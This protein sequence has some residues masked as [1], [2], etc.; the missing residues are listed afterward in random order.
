[1][2]YKKFL[3]SILA[4]YLAFRVIS[5]SPGVVLR[6]FRSDGCSMFIDR[7]L[8]DDKDWCECCLSHD[9]AY[10]RGGSKEER[11]AA[12]R[13]FRECI[14]QMTG[15]GHLADLMYEAVRV[16]G[17]PYFPTWYR[18]GYGWKTMRGYK[19]LIPEEEKLV[20]DRLE[21]YFRDS[22]TDRCSRQ[23]KAIR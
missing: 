17:G 18:W 19:A 6:E 16:G 1:M 12:D 23:R 10:W 14:L 20:Q 21:E 8:I 11:E 15:D 13:E 3:L 2:V 5:C 4:V 22:A 7:S 9:L